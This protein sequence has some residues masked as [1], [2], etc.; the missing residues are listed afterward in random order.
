MVHPPILFLQIHPTY[1]VPKEQKSSI[2]YHIGLI[3]LF[4]TILTIYVQYFGYLIDEL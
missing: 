4:Q 2:K 3:L 1:A